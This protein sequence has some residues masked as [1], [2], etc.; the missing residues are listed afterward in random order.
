MYMSLNTLCILYW[1]YLCIFS[2]WCYNS[3]QFNSLFMSHRA[4]QFL[5]FIKISITIINLTDNLIVFYF[6]YLQYLF[7]LICMFYGNREG[8]SDLPCSTL[9]SVDVQCSIAILFILYIVMVI[10]YTV[11]VFDSN[12]RTLYELMLK[13]KLLFSFFETDLKPGQ[14]CGNKYRSKFSLRST[15]RYSGK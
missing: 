4:I 7:S 13:T 6:G 1:L 9:V 5:L 12:H 15:W 2:T 3:I 11:F 14:R 10:L 8:I